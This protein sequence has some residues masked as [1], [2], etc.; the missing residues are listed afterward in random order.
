MAWIYDDIDKCKV[1][2][3]TCF[4]VATIAYLPVVVVTVAIAIAVVSCGFAHLHKFN[5]FLIVFKQIFLN[6]SRVHREREIEWKRVKSE[7]IEK[8]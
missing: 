6:I 8:R 5:D 1:I 3:N 2:V 7:G 4:T